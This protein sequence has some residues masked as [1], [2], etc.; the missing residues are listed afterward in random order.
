MKYVLIFI[1]YENMKS[2]ILFMYIFYFYEK[3]FFYHF[4][5]RTLI[6]YFKHKNLDN[7]FV[8]KLNQ[9]EF[10]LMLK[11]YKLKV[12]CDFPNSLFNLFNFYSIF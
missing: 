11:K 6:Y 8:S 9:I 2:R 12:K 4:L 1:M 5:L 7:I 3:Y 10:F